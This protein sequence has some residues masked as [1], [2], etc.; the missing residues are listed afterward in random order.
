LK[1]DPSSRAKIASLFNA[2]SSCL[3]KTDK[4][5]K[6]AVF[7]GREK[8]MFQLQKSETEHAPPRLTILCLV[9]PQHLSSSGGI[10]HI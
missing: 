9:T 8:V 2:S 3:A 5:S 10:V 4:K 7:G 1:T 6:E